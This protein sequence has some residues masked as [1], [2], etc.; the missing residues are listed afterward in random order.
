M[1]FLDNFTKGIL[2]R[3]AAGVVAVIAFFPT[4]ILLLLAITGSAP[5]WIPLTIGISA[6]V[7]MVILFIV[8]FVLDLKD[9]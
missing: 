9:Q 2:C 1:S 4:A 5:M 7:I 8:G 6:A 3:I